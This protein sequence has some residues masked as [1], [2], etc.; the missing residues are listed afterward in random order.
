MRLLI[1]T[2][3]RN[4]VQNAFAYI[5][6][7]STKN[8]LRFLDSAQKTFNLLTKKPYMGNPYPFRDSQFSNIRRWFVRDFNKYLIFY[9]VL[10]NTVEII[11][12]LHSSQD[13]E[14]LFED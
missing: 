1:K 7:D 13:I 5:G 9:R 4:D 12:V 8:A 11:R 14:A 10:D 2:Q 3:A 6:A